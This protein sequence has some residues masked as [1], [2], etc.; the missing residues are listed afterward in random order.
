MCEKIDAGPNWCVSLQ[1]EFK[2]N[3][4]P[5]INVTAVGACCVRKKLMSVL[6]E[7]PLRT[8]DDIVWVR[9]QAQSWVNAILKSNEGPV[10][11][12]KVSQSVPPPK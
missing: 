1:A 12:S 8:N 7:S 11:A 2:V 4:E 10:E 3:S 9:D 5:P 6:V